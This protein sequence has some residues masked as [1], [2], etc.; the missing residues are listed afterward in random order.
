MIADKM[1]RCAAIDVSTARWRRNAV[2]DGGR[3]VNTSLP[4]V[5][6]RRT[7]R[8]KVLRESVS[9]QI[10]CVSP[11]FAVL[12][13]NSARRCAPQGRW[14]LTPGGVQRVP[15]GAYFVPLYESQVMIRRAAENVACRPAYAPACCSAMSPITGSLN[16][17]P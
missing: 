7:K 1:M 15:S 5:P 11:V 8:E 2:L 12:E 16:I 4:S 6:D 14:L 9:Y 3:P 13:L 10:S 17:C